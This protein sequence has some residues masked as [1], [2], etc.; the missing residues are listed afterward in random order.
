MINE[1]IVKLNPR[2]IERFF[3][4]SE[5]DQK[6]IDAQYRRHVIMSAKCDLRPDPLFVLEA[7]SEAERLENKSVQ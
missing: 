3:D 1:Y 7:I 4:L 2:A 6:D 5:Q